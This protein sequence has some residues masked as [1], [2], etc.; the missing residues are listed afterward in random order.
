M[1]HISLMD[2]DTK[3]FGYKVARIDLFQDTDLQ[4]NEFIDNLRHKGFRLIYCFADPGDKI[5]N[6][7]MKKCCGYLVDEKITYTYS[8]DRQLIY[9]L[10]PNISSFDKDKPSDDLI[11]LTLQSGIYSRFNKDP[12][13]RNHEYEHLYGEWIRKSVSG[14]IADKVLVYAES[15]YLQGLITLAKKELIGNIGL[16]AVDEACRGKSIGRKL[17]HAA[18]AYFLNND[19]SLVDVVTQRSNKIACRFYES[20]GFEEREL[21]N[22][23]HLWIK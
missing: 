14:E 18:L 2:W 8:I 20:C 15:D 4:I 17:L 21:L 10:D 3:F 11:R 6:E 7:A 12:N 9:D 22:I 16:L 13:F 23:Y 5:S 1:A 19:I